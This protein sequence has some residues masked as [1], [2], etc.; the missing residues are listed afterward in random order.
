A[1]NTLVAQNDST[2]EYNPDLWSRFQWTSTEDGQHYYCQVA[3]DA[4]D[5][6][7]A[8]ALDSADETDPAAGGCGGFP[9]TTLT[10]Q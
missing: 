5:E 10:A 8:W 2:N 4:A 7:T 1:A 3:F 9:W 6:A